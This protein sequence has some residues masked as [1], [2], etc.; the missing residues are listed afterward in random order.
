MYVVHTLGDTGSDETRE[1]TRDQRTRVEG[2][3][4]EAQLL[5][6]VPGTQKVKATRL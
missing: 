3:S 6:S 1:S 5:A 2:G 4:S